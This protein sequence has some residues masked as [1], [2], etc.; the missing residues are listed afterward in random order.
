VNFR[1]HPN[2]ERLVEKA[3]AS[4][5]ASRNVAGITPDDVAV[6]RLYSHAYRGQVIG[7]FHATQAALRAAT[8]EW[9]GDATRRTAAL[10]ATE[11]LGDLAAQA[12]DPIAADFRALVST[13]YRY[14]TNI[15]RAL[16]ALTAAGDEP[17]VGPI[18]RRFLAQIERIA[19]SAGIACT[20]DDEVPEQASFVVPNLGITIVPLVYGD[21]H[22]WNLAYLG[23]DARDVPR[24]RHVQGVEIHLGMGHVEGFTL[25]GS[26]RAEVKEGYAMAIPP[27]TAHGFVNTSGKEH[28]LPFVFGSKEL[29][30]WGIFLDVE[31]QPIDIESLKLVPRSGACL[32]GLVYLDREIERAEKLAGNARWTLVK[33]E[34]TFK[35]ESGALVLSIARVGTTGMSLPVDSFRTVSVVRGQGI[36]RI[37]SVEQTVSA[38]DHFGVPAGLAA[39]LEP[40][41]REPLVILDAILVTKLGRVV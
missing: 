10:Q 33:P 41:G 18:A 23:G 17:P 13:F 2:Y 21:Q 5:A 11:L 4:H 24:H 31:A 26:Q 1:A 12:L 27:N 25:L 36:V 29:S 22:S 40:V 7:T 19:G 39:S 37:G 30:G 8:A 6:A 14:D 3:R 20:R 32:N 38:H 16:A 28:Y 35:P 15:R 34:A 9:K